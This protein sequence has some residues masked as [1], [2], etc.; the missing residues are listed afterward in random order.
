MRFILTINPGS[1]STKIAIFRLTDSSLQS[2]E[3]ITSQNI[4]YSGEE[5]LQN[6]SGILALLAEHQVATVDCIVA[7]GGLVKPLAA[8]S[9]AISQQMIDDLSNGRYGMHA[10]NFGALIADKLSKKFNCQALIVDPVG[11]DE[12][13]TLARYSGI[14]EIERRSQ[15]HALNIRATARLA[16][17]DLATAMEKVNFVVAHLGGGIS[18]VPLMHGKIIDANNA[19]DGGP[20]SPQRAGSLP[21]TQLV[22]LAFSGQ[23]KTPKELI[24]KLTKESGL[25]AYLN[26]DN[27]I[28]IVKRINN[29]DKVAEEIFQAMAYQISKEIGSM[30]TV[31]K[32]EVDAIIITGGLARPP[33]ADW[34]Q[35]SVNWIA[36]VMVYPGEREQEALAQA[37]ARFLC[38]LEKLLHYS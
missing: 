7:R 25:R 31:L 32:G 8:G 14:P 10:S 3:Q 5:L 17:S 1:T 23:F 27:G 37:G 19:N 21:I 2:L 9:Y 20:F 6:P 15:S 18:I 38:G 11:V 30:A 12:F 36:P 33:L 26:T 28:E 24:T 13:I 35:E 22:K 4:Q 16:A 29:G 34:I